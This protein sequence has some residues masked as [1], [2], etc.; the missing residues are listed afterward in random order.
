MTTSVIALAKYRQHLREQLLIVLQ[1]GV[2][3][4]DVGRGRGEH[5]FGAGRGEA[6][7]AEPLHAAHA[8]VEPRLLAHAVSGAVGR[9]VVYYDHLPMNAFERF[10]QRLDQ[11]HDIIA[12][13]KAGCDDGQ[14]GT[15]V[16]RR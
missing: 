10:G 16:K 2:D 6:A 9:I 5:R 13:I 11:R 1:V 4:R 14:L 3:D 7:A 15:L 12:L 8:A